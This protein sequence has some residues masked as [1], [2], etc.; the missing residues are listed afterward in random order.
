MAGLAGSEA[1][2]HPGATGVGDLQAGPTWRGYRGRPWL[3]A[4]QAKAFAVAPHSK[5]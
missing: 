4:L 5:S 1:L 2:G 3:V